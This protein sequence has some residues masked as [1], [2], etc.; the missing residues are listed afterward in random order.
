MK[1]KDEG[2]KDLVSRSK[3]KT[4]K[5]DSRSKDQG[6]QRAIRSESE[7]R[8]RRRIGNNNMKRQVEKR[9]SECEEVRPEGSKEG[10]MDNRIM[11]EGE[12]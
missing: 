2:L 7:G 12:E 9:K 6:P 3:T 5:Q 11:K 10:L 1:S 8:M 4:K